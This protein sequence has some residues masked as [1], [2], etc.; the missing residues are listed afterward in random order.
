MTGLSPQR[1]HASILP[2]LVDRDPGDETSFDVGTDAPAFPEV[3][4]WTHGYLHDD[5]SEES[6]P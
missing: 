1:S 4:V 3:S 2:P 5:Y 6:R